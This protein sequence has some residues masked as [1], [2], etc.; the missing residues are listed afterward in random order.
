MSVTIRPRRDEDLPAL[1][2]AL[3]RVHAQDGYPVEGV[4]DPEGWLRHDRELQSWTAVEDGLPIGQVALIRAVPE[5]DAARAWREHSHGDIDRLAIPARLFVDPG[6]R[7][8]GAGQLL[9]EAVFGFAR[10]RG[11]AIAFD[12]MLK[13]QAAIRLYERLGAV[14]I[15]DLT[16]HY[17]DGL[18]EPA[19]VYVAAS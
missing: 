19:A 16:H 9:M 17:G 14:R 18:N 12:V 7:G 15:A 3:V 4:A 10:A 2:A 5:D 8:T 13:D 1:A 11:L 6:H